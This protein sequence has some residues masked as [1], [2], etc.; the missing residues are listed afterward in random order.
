MSVRTFRWFALASFIAMILII[1]TGAAV[2][3]T[4]SGL[5]CPDWPTCYHGQISGSW[6]LHPAV[7]Y[8]NRLVTVALSLVTV[9]TLLAAV[10]RVPYR[11]DLTLFAGLLVVGVVADALLG[12]VVVY[13]KLNPWL[14][15]SHLIVSLGMVVAGAILYHRSKYLYGPGTRADLRDGRFRRIARLLWVPFIL[16]VVAGTITTG[17]GPHAGSARGQMRARRLP[18]SL[19]DVAWI[20]SLAAVMLV[21][22]VI[23]LF[24]LVWKSD[25]PERLQRGVRRLATIGA[26]QGVVGG[27]QYVTHLPV[28][29]VEIHV[30]LAASLAIGVTQFHL[31]QTARDREVGLEK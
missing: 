23:G 12:A 9:A 19:S 31:S 1:A 22:M 24:L 13:T 6:S 18:F 30:C 16:T 29:L 7:E 10:R 21:S 28:V 17:S 3:L 26:V 2:R 27:V 5:G 4:G 20:H 15:S 14:V 11:R 25:A 8:A